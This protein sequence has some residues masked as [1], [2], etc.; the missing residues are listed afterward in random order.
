M[1]SRIAV[2]LLSRGTNSHA[3]HAER[4]NESCDQFSAFNFRADVKGWKR[5]EYVSEVTMFW[6]KYNTT[7]TYSNVE[8]QEDAYWY[9]KTVCTDIPMYHVP[10]PNWIKS[11]K[12]TSCRNS[13]SGTWYCTHSVCSYVPKN[14]REKLYCLFLDGNFSDNRLDV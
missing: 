11:R 3:Q 5:L 13:L 9:A 14:E 7:R 12:I 10:I 2:V 8:R 6:F 4:W 1:V